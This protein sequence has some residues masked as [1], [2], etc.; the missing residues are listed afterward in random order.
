MSSRQFSTLVV[1]V[2]KYE[3]FRITQAYWMCVNR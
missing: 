3:T 1:R 2:L